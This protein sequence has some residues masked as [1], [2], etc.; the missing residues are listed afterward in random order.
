MHKHK[1]DISKKLKPPF[2]GKTPLHQQ[3]HGQKVA[4]NF[5][6]FGI[7]VSGHCD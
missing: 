4:K 1:P 6:S 3:N 7:S 5:L 2:N